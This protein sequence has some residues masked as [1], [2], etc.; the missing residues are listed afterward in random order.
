M[1]VRGERDM[2]PTIFDQIYDEVENSPLKTSYKRALAVRKWRIFFSFSILSISMGFL[3]G[4]NGGKIELWAGLT[5]NLSVVAFLFSLA[6]VYMTLIYSANIWCLYSVEY[7]LILTNKKNQISAGKES[8]MQEAGTLLET[9]WTNLRAELDLRKAEGREYQRAYE[10]MKEEHAS[11]IRKLERSYND[12]LRTTLRFDILIDV[13]RFGII[14][15]LAAFAVYH[16]WKKMNFSEFAT[17]LF[18]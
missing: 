8:V 3:N 10:N 15:P 14:F 9:R 11:A 2:V 13:F 6:V 12:K 7:G 16:A 17:I 18:S 4:E 1:G 5:I